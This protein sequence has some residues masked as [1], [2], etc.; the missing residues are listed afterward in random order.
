MSKETT[1]KLLRSESININELTS[2]IT[3]YL[4]DLNREFNVKQLNAIIQLIQ[5]GHL[6]LDDSIN[7]FINKYNL[8]VVRI[9]DKQGQ[10]LKTIVN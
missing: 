1:I 6:T 8:N 4:T 2:Y 7:Y 10:L 5:V 3:N 9:Y